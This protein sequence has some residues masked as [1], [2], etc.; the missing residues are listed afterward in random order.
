MA[1]SMERMT[2]WGFALLALLGWDSS[3]RAQGN[4]FNPYG[5]SGY[6]D[7]REFGSPKFDTNTSPSLPG[8]S[9]VNSEPLITRP[10]ANSFQQYTDSLDGI[11][12]DPISGRSSSRGSSANQPYYQA[13]RQYDKKYDRVYRPN[14]LADKDFT[15]RLDRRDQAYTAAL[16]EKD[17]AKRAQMLRD[18]NRDSLDRLVPSRARPATSAAQPKRAGATPAPATRPTTPGATARRAPAP[19]PYPPTASSPRAAGRAP[20]AGT[21]PPRATGR[22]TAPP[23]PSTIAVPAPR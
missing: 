1:A 8:Q 11:D 9:R 21:T 15:R 5:N 19:S 16:E 14:A 22:G 20:S 4:I 2:P 12:S 10:R 13:F 18:L 23:N 3:A 17:P 6:A 7:Y